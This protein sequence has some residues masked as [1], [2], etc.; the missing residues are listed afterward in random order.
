MYTHA[1]VL[2]LK[3]WVLAPF[4]GATRHRLRVHE[5]VQETPGVVSIVLAGKHLEELRAESGQLFRWRFLT[6]TPGSPPTRFLWPRPR[7]QTGCA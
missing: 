5:V 1:F 6:P 2:V 7:A 4:Q 3:Y